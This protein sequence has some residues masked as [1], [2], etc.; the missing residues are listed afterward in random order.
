[1]G[2]NS[3]YIS[4]EVPNIVYYINSTIDASKRGR[5]QSL[6]HL[7]YETHQLFATSIT[8]RNLK[9]LCVGIVVHNEVYL[10]LH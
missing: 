1:M 3:A 8:S 6:F 9:D 2:D 5:A 4:N 7:Q 10:T